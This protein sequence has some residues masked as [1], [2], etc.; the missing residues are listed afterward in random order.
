MP[1]RRETQRMGR[2][3]VLRKKQGELRSWHQHEAA[4]ATRYH[5]DTVIRTALALL[6]DLLRLLE[7]TLRSRAQRA[8]ENLFLRKQLAYY[9]ERNVRLKRADNASR[10]AL[11]LLARFVAWRELLTI[12]RPDTLV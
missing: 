10:V 12:V 3:V 8:V 11:V 9:I 5:C 7:L 6:T 2:T 1:E 4:S